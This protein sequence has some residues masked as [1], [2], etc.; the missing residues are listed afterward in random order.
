MDIGRKFTRHLP[1]KGALSS[2]MIRVSI[3]NPFTQCK[4]YLQVCDTTGALDL[5]D[6][7]FNFIDKKLRRLSA[8]D[9]AR[10]G[11]T[12]D[13]DSAIRELNHR[14]LEHG[15]GYQFEGGELN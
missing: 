7:T 12:Q 2:L 3:F 5:I 10:T 6:L 14:L 11:I 8:Y 9:R 15:I 1:A 13:P 4:Q